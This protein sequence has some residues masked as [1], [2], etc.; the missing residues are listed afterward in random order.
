MSLYCLRRLVSSYPRFAA[1]VSLAHVQYLRWNHQEIV[2]LPSEPDEDHELTPYLFVS[3]LALPNH[4]D[5]PLHVRVFLMCLFF[6]AARF[7]VRQ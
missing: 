3:I 1:V 5:I 7:S 2:D 4:H 6:C